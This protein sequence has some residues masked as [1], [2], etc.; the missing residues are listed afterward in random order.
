VAQ[1]RDVWT[2]VD[3]FSGCGGLSY[4]FAHRRRFRII[5]AVD[6]EEGKPC[7][8][9]GTLNCNS[10]YAKN[11]GIDPLKRNIA[12]LRAQK[13]FDDVRDLVTPPL[14]RGDLTV[15][16]CSPPCT[17][18]SRAKPENHLNDSAKNPLVV[19]C[20]NF[21][22]AFLPQFVVLENARELIR[23]NHG[24]H[25][26]A[27]KERLE[28]LGYAVHGD[29][30]MLTDYGLP[31]TR[32]R[33]I[34]IA[35]RIGP[36]RAIEELWEGWSIRKGATSVRHAIGYLARRALKAGEV[37]RSDMMH[38]A[39]G[40]SDTVR[41]RI[42]AIPK[43][44]GSWTDLVKHKRYRTLL[45]PS[46]RAKLGKSTER[47]KKRLS[48]TDVYGRLAW[49]RPAVTIKRECAHVGNGRYVHPHQNRLLS[50][51]EM[52]VLKGFPKDYSFTAKG[53]DNRY[54]HVGDAVPPLIAYQLSALVVW[55][56]TE[57]RPRPREWVLSGTSLRLTDVRAVSRRR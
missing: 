44:G 16:L 3:L 22:E 15:L 26:K 42:A 8:G 33:A 56:K 29:V 19:R 46:M 53:I 52:A 2:V 4:G 43:D 18:F 57:K 32:E 48:H 10:T 20:A 6:A 13:L 41:R 34:V 45:I 14:R 21:V 51:R 23:G 1:D 39:P 50:I 30:Y 25:Y 54:R 55:M 31:Q 24:H 40:L 49:D 17:D 9:R 38:R 37:D 27:F 7:D 11:I 12:T 28:Q 36:V 5:A 47:R 35:S